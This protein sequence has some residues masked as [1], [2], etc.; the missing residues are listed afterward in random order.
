MKVGWRLGRQKEKIQ[1]VMRKEELKFQARLHSK[2]L[3]KRLKRNFFIVRT[4]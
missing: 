4:L 3:L 2:I 1:K